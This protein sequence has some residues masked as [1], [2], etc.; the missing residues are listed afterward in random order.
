MRSSV[1][2]PMPTSGRFSSS[3]PLCAT[4]PAARRPWLSLSSDR[5][6]QA[7]YNPGLRREHARARLRHTYRRHEP[8]AA[9]QVARHIETIKHAS[10]PKAR[11]ITGVEGAA[12]SARASNRPDTRSARPRPHISCCFTESSAALRVRLSAINP[13]WHSTAQGHPP[14]PIAPARPWCRFRSHPCR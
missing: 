11:P 6:A 2:P 4:G 9:G 1:I 7:R 3:V 12:M 8:D 14:N 5:P 10:S 13:E